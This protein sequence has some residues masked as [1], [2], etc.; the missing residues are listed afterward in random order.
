MNGVLGAR[1]TGLN[2]LGAFNAYEI[3]AYFSRIS[4]APARHKLRS[5]I[6]TT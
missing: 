6:S 1:R 2:W 5:G 4:G 3:N